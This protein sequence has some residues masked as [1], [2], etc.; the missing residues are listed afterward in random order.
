MWLQPINSDA[1]DVEIITL[2]CS[3]LDAVSSNSSTAASTVDPAA[4][5]E[6]AVFVATRAKPMYS[7][8]TSQKLSI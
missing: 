3:E 1:G 7:K 2:L 6:T 5:C 4:G 8:S